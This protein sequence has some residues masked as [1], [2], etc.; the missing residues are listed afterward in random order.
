MTG[1]NAAV[2]DLECLNSWN[3]V[4][5][6]RSSRHY[7]ARVAGQALNIGVFVDQS[8][9]IGRIEDVHFNPWFS[10]HSPFICKDGC[11]RPLTAQPIQLG[12][13]PSAKPTNTNS[14]SCTVS[15][16]QRIGVQPAPRSSRPAAP[17]NH[18]N[19][20]AIAVA[21]HGAWFTR[22]LGLSPRE[23]AS[24]KTAPC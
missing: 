14:T 24:P 1:D 21:E 15:G 17:L 6:V 18:T 5:A 20:K 9:D 4:A 22:S 7:I 11:H 12:V 16:R 23:S 13:L 10:V 3:C 19:A 2:T 8:Y